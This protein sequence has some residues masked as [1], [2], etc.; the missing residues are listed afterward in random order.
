MAKSKALLKAE[1]DLQETAEAFS[2]AGDTIAELRTENTSFAEN[3]VRHQRELETC[4]SNLERNNRRYTD[5]KLKA[6][7]LAKDYTALALAF[8]ATSVRGHLASDAAK[9]PFASLGITDYDPERVFE[10]YAEKI[11]G[12]GHWRPEQSEE[13][14]KTETGAE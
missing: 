12:G 4:H 8:V 9:G 5:V 7:K 3:A 11:P 1:A 13:S 2:R 10:Y 6:E 14:A